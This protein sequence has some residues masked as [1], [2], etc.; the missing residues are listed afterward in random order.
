MAEETPG[1]FQGVKPKERT[2]DLNLQIP[3]NIVTLYAT[4]LTVQSVNDGVVVAFYEALP[5]LVLGTQEEVD[6]IL[7]T[8]NTIPANCVGRF[9]ISNT[10]FP[11]FVRV[12]NEALAKQQSGA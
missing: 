4:N 10:Q 12:M 2:Y 1:D 5:P 3:Q 8:I 6:K 9:M 7:D 11:N